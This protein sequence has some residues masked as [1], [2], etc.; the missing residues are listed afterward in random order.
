MEYCLTAEVLSASRMGQAGTEKS[1]VLFVTI[2]SWF[3]NLLTKEH[4]FLCDLRALCGRMSLLPVAIFPLFSA[5]RRLV[6]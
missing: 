5:V 1:L 3:V 2:I 6:F 4:A